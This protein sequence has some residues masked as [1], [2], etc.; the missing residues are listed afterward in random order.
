MTQ[1]PIGKVTQKIMFSVPISTRV[2]DIIAVDLE[3]GSMTFA[4][5]SGGNPSSVK[6]MYDITAYIIRNTQEHY[7]PD[8]GGHPVYNV[9]YADMCKA[10]NVPETT[11]MNEIIF[12]EET[13]KK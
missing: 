10:F 9:T 7:P 1:K 6:G 2:S 4:Q 3:D 11:P 13:F 5:V 8:I 12:W